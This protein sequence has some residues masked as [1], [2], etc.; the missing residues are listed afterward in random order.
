MYLIMYCRLK[1]S[2]LVLGIHPTTISDAF[3]N[4]AV[5]GCEILDSMSTPVALNDRESLLQSA[6][7]SL[8]SKVKQG[9]F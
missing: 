5:K 3:Q 7:T 8:N 9:L 1:I 4:A 2:S 6:S